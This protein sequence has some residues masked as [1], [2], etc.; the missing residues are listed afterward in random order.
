ML[1]GWSKMKMRFSTTILGTALL[2]LA[3]TTGFLQAQHAADSNRPIPEPLKA[4]LRSYLSFGGKTPSDT[5]TRITVFSVKTK[6][7]KTEEDIVYVSGDRWCGSGGCTMLILQPTKSTFKVL[8]RVTIVQLP[9]RLLPSV[10]NGHP[11]I[12]VIV[13]GGGILQGY[14]A[15]LSFD[16]KRYPTNPSMRP[17]RKATA[18][19]GKVIIANTEGSV[20]LY[21]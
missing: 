5:T 18:M 6:D 1:L 21:D 2:T 12:G 20:P 16:G 3:G 17:A 11:D 14:E 15:V 13:Q 9:I 7:G 10:H 19:G 4:Y 8:G